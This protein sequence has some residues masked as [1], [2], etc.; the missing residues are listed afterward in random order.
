VSSTVQESAWQ[1]DPLPRGRHKLGMEEVRASQRARIARAIIEVVA[2]HGYEAATVTQVVT[3]ARV[4]RNAFY[5][6][7]TDKSDAFTTVTEEKGRELLDA[8]LAMAGE[9]NWIDAIRRGTALYLAW[10]Q[11]HATFG[12]AYFAGLA[13][14]GP[15]G[16]AQRERGYAPFVAM[17]SELGRRARVEQPKLEPLSPLV[18]RALVFAITEIV[19]EELR[20][21]REDQLGELAPDLFRL[22]VRLLGDDETAR[23]AG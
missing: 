14:L 1:G 8:M 22:L 19:A 12:R 10:W 20:H 23:A 18:P 2:E 15:R 3:A 21:G 13:E 7:F 16:L 17:F 5:E 9:D 4:S 11:E 6:F